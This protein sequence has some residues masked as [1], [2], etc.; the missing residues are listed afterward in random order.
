[1]YRRPFLKGTMH[2][3]AAFVGI[4]RHAGTTM[5]SLDEAFRLGRVKN[6]GQFGHALHP[7]EGR[8]LAFPSR[9]EQSP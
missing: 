2:L 8:S 9:P 4:A 3:S 5:L 1:M 7:S 6:R